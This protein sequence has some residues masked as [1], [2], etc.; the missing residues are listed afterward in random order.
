VIESTSVRRFPP[1]TPAHPRLIR[2][3][4]EWAAQKR[5][6]LRYITGLQPADFELAYDASDHD[7]WIGCFKR[8]EILLRWGYLECTTYYK[9]HALLNDRLAKYIGNAKRDN[10]DFIGFVFPKTTAERLRKHLGQVLQS[11]GRD[12]HFH[13]RVLTLVAKG[14]RIIE[15]PVECQ[16]EDSDAQKRSR[17]DYYTPHLRVVLEYACPT[18]KAIGFRVTYWGK[19]IGEYL[20]R[21]GFEVDWDRQQAVFEVPHDRHDEYKSKL[22]VAR[23][24]KKH[25]ETK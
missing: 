1:G 2:A 14:D 20:K 5:L 18:R 15:G 4:K 7:E 19:E 25:C 24:W 21:N 6:D 23:G 22:G 9:N 11:V 3:V 13:G 16:R 10:A 12:E 8:R 17:L